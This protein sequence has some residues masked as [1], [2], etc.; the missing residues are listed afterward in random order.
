MI[1]LIRKLI[2][3]YKERWV[4]GSIIIIAANSGGAWSPIGDVTTIMSW[5]KGNISTEATIP[6]LILPSMVSAIVPTLFIM[7][8]MHGN[9]TAPIITKEVN[10]NPLLSILADREKLALLVLGVISLLFVPVFKTITHLPPFVGILMAVGAL[11]VYTEIMYQ[12]KQDIDENIKLRLANVIRRIDGA[13]LMFFLGILLAV[14]VLRYSGIL[15]NF[16]TWLDENIGNVFAVNIIIGTLSAIVD[17]VPLVAGAIGMYPIATEAMVEAAAN[18]EY[19]S[20]FLQDGVFWQFL[21]YC[22][23]V[24]GSMLIIGSAAGVV[25]MGLERINFIWYLKNI[26]FLAML[27]YL[28]GAAVYIIQ[29]MIF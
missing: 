21:A 13:T 14:E 15:T 11:W 24:G 2:G 18:P 5:V 28:S 4:F 29:T 25:V 26:S 20:H 8:K 1:M 10:D 6:N 23:G 19:L 17:N 22:A 16:S 9:V 12:K 27:G 3:N 7:R